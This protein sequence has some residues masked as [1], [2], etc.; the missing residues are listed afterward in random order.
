[1]K[2]ASIIWTEKEKSWN[3]LHFLEYKTEIMQ[4][5]LQIQ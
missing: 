2:N 3:K 1:M 4:H 5:L